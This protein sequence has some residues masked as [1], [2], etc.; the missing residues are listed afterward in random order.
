M[1]RFN[2]KEDQ[3]LSA[4]RQPV[5]NRHPRQRSRV[6]NSHKLIS[7]S[8]MA[9]P[10]MH[11]AERRTCVLIGTLAQASEASADDLDV[12]ARISGNMLESA[13]CGRGTGDRS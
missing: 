2:P 3:E 12:Y 13:C 9:S 10:D 1:V 4:D 8:D 7:I 5:D 11:S 6:G